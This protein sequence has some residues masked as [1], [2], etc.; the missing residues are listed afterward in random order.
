MVKKVFHIGE[1]V[2]SLFIFIILHVGL[3]LYEKSTWMWMI[4]IFAMLVCLYQVVKRVQIST[5]IYTT[6]IVAYT[7]CIF[8]AEWYIMNTQMP[9]L[10]AD[11]EIIQY[12][13]EWYASCGD[14]KEELREYFSIFPN[15]INIYVSST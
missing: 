3:F 13:T 14:I 10:I 4:G 11:F 12:Q 7:L 1:L 5:R 8:G 15:N 9:T 2:L 6:I